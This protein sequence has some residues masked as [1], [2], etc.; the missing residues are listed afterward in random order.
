MEFSSAA[1]MG[2]AGERCKQREETN[3]RSISRKEEKQNM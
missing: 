2:R 3:R 1:E